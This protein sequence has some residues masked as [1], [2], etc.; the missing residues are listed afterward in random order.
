ML[1]LLA[2]VAVIG[3][4]WWLWTVVQWVWLRPKA[5]EKCLRKQGLNGPA[6]R[7]LHGDMNQ[8]ATM[9][10]HAAMNSKPISFSDDFLP[11]ILP[12]HHHIIE[13]YVQYQ[14]CSTV[15]TWATMARDG[16]SCVR[17]CFIVYTMNPS[18]YGNLFCLNL[19]T[20]QVNF[21]NFW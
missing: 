9:A 15:E 6:Y 13:T 18:S 1:L 14:W 20:D 17:S 19:I 8:M 5:I 2:S 4:A 16:G 11:I 10:R 7:L 3:G 21:S 12:F